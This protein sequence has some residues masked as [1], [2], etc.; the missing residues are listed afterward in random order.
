VLLDP[1]DGDD[2]KDP[3]ARKP[4]KRG[5]AL[6]LIAAAAA[7]VAAGTSIPMA[8]RQHYESPDRP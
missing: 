3:S 2:S 1:A 4:R 8:T 6:V 5:K 7:A